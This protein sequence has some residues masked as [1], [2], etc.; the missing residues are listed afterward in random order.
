[1]WIERR[2]LAAELPAAAP[3]ATREL[4]ELLA[5]LGFPV[6]AIEVRPGTE[7][8][9]VDITANRGDAMSHHGMARDLAARL[10]A[11]L[12]P[13][14]PPPAPEGPAKVAVHLPDPGCPVY[15]TALLTLG[16]G[17]TPEVVQAFLTAL[18]ASP[19]KLPAVDASNELLHRYG[20]PTHAFDADRIHGAV[21]VRRAVAG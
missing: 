7:V 6:D 4:A 10:K 17:E 15:A 18:G 1:M 16:A 21:T 11:P 14:A 2:A 20:H 12:A 19:K 5:S 9:D 13:L 3:L 8:L